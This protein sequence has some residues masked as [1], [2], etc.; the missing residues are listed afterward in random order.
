MDIFFTDPTDIPLP[1]EE[2]R[3]RHFRAEPWPDKRRVRITLEITP[4]QKGPNSEIEIRDAEGN[5][6]ASLTIIE[7]INPK[8]DMTV[9]LRVA[10]PA[11]S[12]TA[13]A[14]VYYYEAEEKTES[15][16]GGAAEAPLPTL[17]SKV[18]LVDQA[19]TTFQI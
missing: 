10:E 19:E 9:H 12:Y 13:S 18:K 16:K 6:V 1:P 7:T 4:F 11:G 2:V 8:M 15:A 14:T 17:P 5:E 3:I